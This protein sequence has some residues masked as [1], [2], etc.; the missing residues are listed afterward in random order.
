MANKINHSIQ[1]G[2][3]APDF[4]AETT[5]GKISFHQWIGNSWCILFSHPKDFTPVCTTELGRAAKLTTDFS[6][7][8]TKL[9]ALSIGSVE[10]HQQ[11]I[12][13][14]NKSQ[15]VN[16]TFPIIADENH[17]VSELYHMIHPEASETATVRSV[18]ILDPKKVIR[19]IL[20]YPASTGRNFQ[21]IL[22]VLDSLQLTDKYKVA[23]PVDWIRGE[24]CVIL[25]SITDSVEIKKLFPKGFRQI[26][27]YLRLTP[28][29]SNSEHMQVR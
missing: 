2:A 11:W 19:L 24:E 16:L 20:T 15:G 3:I 13:D 17:A 25:P 26:T 21:E 4:T 23:T 28:D 7:R 29:P 22:R 14:I 1:L 5:H 9:I 27:P 18:F 10:N 6:Q 12:P 8:G